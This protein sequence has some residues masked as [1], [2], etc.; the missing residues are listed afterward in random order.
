[1]FRRIA[2]RALVSRGC[3][4]ADRRFCGAKLTRTLTFSGGSSATRWIGGS[5]LNCSRS[6]CW[7]VPGRNRKS[8]LLV[9]RRQR[10]LD[11]PE[12]RAN[13]FGAVTHQPLDLVSTF[14]DV[15]AAL[16]VGI[17]LGFLVDGWNFHPVKEVNR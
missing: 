13:A 1:M 3:S 12:G 7:I 14:A 16:E 6:L 4:V 10:R 5:S 15:K 8:H 2:V 11:V 9:F 17:P